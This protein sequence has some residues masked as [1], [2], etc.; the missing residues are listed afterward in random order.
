MN[1][2]S[3]GDMAQSFHLR[4][5]NAE[6]K[7][8]ITRLTSELSS[9]KVQDVMKHL[10]ADLNY[11]TDI[12]RSL[13][14]NS[15]FTRSAH[16]AAGFS[17]A[18]Q[19]G[20][21]YLQQSIS[22]LGADILGLGEGS[23]TLT[24]NLLAQKGQGVIEGLV[25]TLNTSVAGRALFSG[26][27]TDRAALASADTILTDLRAALAGQ[28]TI[29][30]IETAMDDWFGAGGGYE[31]VAYTGGTSDMSAFHLGDG[32]RVDLKI[33][34]DDAAFKMTLKSAAMAALSADAALVLSDATRAAMLERA[35]ELSL[36]AV[37]GLTATRGAL[38]YAEA[39]IEDAG[40][41]LTA[42]NTSLEIARTEL[43]S[44]DPYDTIVKL[45]A[46]QFRLESLYTATAKLS[47]LSLVGFL[48]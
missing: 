10:G 28:A 39:R 47:Q 17:A 19:S 6:L 11:L 4:R 48:R 40:I 14:M 37:D 20:L 45:E 25:S 18:M 24:N 13:Q 35:G 8:E 38:G 26:N 2:V 16:E 9:G 5:Q 1:S 22:D 3:I 34:G 41:R 7:T 27:A 15:V 33:K 29:A 32:E 44:A 23:N 42:Q 43:L 21:T 46:T 31:T 36:S 12:E 30:D